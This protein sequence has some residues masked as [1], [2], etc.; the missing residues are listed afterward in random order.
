MSDNIQIEV[1]F[2][3]EL[4]VII[5]IGLLIFLSVGAFFNE[6]MNYDDSDPRINYFVNTIIKQEF[7][8]WLMGGSLSFSGISLTLLMYSISKFKEETNE[9]PRKFYR[10]MSNIMHVITLFIFIIVITSII[11][12]IFFLRYLFYV[13][14]FSYYIFL[15]TVLLTISDLM[16]MEV[17]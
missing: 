14:L 11:N 7:S 5:F 2:L 4:F 12:V 3:L 13:S 1:G 9:I 15:F 16:R 6:F 17:R 8:K 10:K